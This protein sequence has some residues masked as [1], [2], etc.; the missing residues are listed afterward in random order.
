MKEE[1]SQWTLQKN[2]YKEYYEKLYTNNL[3]N[4]EEMG[5]F[6]E[7]YKLPKLKQEEY[8]PVQTNKEVKK[9]N[10]L[11]KISEQTRVQ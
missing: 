3:G 1:R 2:K 7:T 9:L 11:S 6:Q 5:K 8:L 4:L 10:Q